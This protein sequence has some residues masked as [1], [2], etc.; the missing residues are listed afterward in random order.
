MDDLER[1][2]SLLEIMDQT[3]IRTV[4]SALKTDLD[5]GTRALLLAQSDA[6][7]AA[8]AEEIA[9]LTRLCGIDPTNQVQSVNE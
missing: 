6:G 9:V 7:G 3:C 5:P 8:A 4:N 1:F 2:E